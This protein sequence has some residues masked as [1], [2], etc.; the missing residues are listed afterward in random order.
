MAGLLPGTATIQAR[1]AA[2]GMQAVKMPHGELRGHTFHYAR[3]EIAA[4]PFVLADN[5]TGGP[6]REAIYRRGGLT[7]SFVHFYFPSHPAAAVALF[8]P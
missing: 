3:A 8:L 5:P 4:T 2:L 7:A 6:S 1:F